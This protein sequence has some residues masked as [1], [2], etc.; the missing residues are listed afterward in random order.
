[1]ILLADSGSTKTDWVVV[2]DGVTVKTFQTVGL[3]PYFVSTG[4]ATDILREP[5]GRHLDSFSVSHIYF[6]GAGCSSASKKAVIQGALETLL[7]GAKAETEHDLLAAARGLFGQ[8]EGIAGILGTGSNSCVYDGE[9]ITEQLFSLGYMF[10]DE[11][12]GA[13]LGKIYIADH[14]K[15][16]APEEIRQAFVKSHGLSDEDILTHIYKKAN[17]N[18]FLASF[19]RFL[20]E[21]IDNPYVYSLVK[22]CFDAYFREQICVFSGYQNKPFGCIGSIGF[23]FREVVEVSARESGVTPEKFMASPIEGLIRY[24]TG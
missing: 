22:G 17:P 7:P 10:G 2:N 9:K 19:T 23:H 15:K 24:H 5:F 18:R 1:M 12:S 4:E 14:L 8:K 16:R 21:N 3:N 11:G 13:H 6:Y 20:K